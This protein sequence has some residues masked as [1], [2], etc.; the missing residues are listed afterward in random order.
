MK[1]GVL[2]RR[3][4]LPA[5]VVSVICYLKFRARVSHRAEVELS[6]NLRLGRGAQ[7]SSFCKVK[8]T[9]GPLE[10]GN[11]T[12]VAAGS[13]LGGMSGGLIIGHDVLIGPNCTVLSSMYV[14]DDLTKPMRV[15]GHTSL[16][17]RIGNN[18]LLGAGTVVLDGAVIG[19]GVIAAPNSVIG[20]HIADN[21]VVSGNPARVVFTR[22]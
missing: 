15:Q 2:L 8:T 18:V 20:G 7:I 19:N 10:I 9:N 12:H 11:D 16:G 1:A 22:R 14:Y 21:S 6:P 4:L 13:T 3:F 17:T 5:P